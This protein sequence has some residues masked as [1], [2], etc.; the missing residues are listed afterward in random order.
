MPML[1][2]DAD[3]AEIAVVVGARCGGRGRRRARLRQPAQAANRRWRTARHQA[4]ATS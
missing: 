4:S 3:A 2:I 1:G